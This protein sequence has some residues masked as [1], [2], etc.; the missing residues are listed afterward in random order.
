MRTETQGGTGRE[1]KKS[2]ANLVLVYLMGYIVGRTSTASERKFGF[3][4]PSAKVSSVFYIK[5]NLCQSIEWSEFEASHISGGAPLDF[6]RGSARCSPLPPPFSA[7]VARPPGGGQGGWGFPAGPPA[8]HHLPLSFPPS[9]ARPPSLQPPQALRSAP[10]HRTSAPV[11]PTRVRSSCVGPAHRYTSFDTCIY[12][13]H[14]Q[15]PPATASH[16]PVPPTTSPPQRTLCAG[17]FVSL[18][19]VS[20]APSL[21]HSHTY[22]AF[23][24]HSPRI[25]S[26]K[27]VRAA[28]AVEDAIV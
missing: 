14:H 23:H 21:H 22:T 12:I 28:R 20:R 7:R 26:L 8:D 2:T 1:A 6:L 18:P 11:H 10:V 5:T 3:S 9:P 16:S 4:E 25:L 24:I 27:P 19:F 15:T 13:F 17:S